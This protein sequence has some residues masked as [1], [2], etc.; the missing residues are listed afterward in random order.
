MFCQWLVNAGMAVFSAKVMPQ[1]KL[2]SMVATLMLM[3]F[4]NGEH[5]QH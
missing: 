4:A 1:A 2:C 3:Q 5:N